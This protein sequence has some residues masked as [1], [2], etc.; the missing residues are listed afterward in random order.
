[1][2]TVFSL[3]VES[4]TNVNGKK[5]FARKWKENSRKVEGNQRRWKNGPLDVGEGWREKENDES[6]CD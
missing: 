6:K 1:M 2:F 4:S 3:G 5:F